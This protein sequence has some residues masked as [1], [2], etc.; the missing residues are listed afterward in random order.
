M[1][2]DTHHYLRATSH[3]FRDLINNSARSIL[4]FSRVDPV[5]MQRLL[6]RMHLANQPDV[7]S[8][9]VPITMSSPVN[10]EV[11]GRGLPHT[12]PCGLHESSILFRMV[13]IPSATLQP[14]A[15]SLSGDGSTSRRQQRAV[16]PAKFLKGCSTPVRPVSY[17][18]SIKSAA[19]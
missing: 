6:D 16:C 12:L 1:S 10:L 2:A 17:S 11:L 18:S 8:L 7:A 4:D 5:S 3:P 15:G 19:G 14:W 9:S 13:R